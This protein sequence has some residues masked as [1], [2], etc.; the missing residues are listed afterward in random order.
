MIL[1]IRIYLTRP[2]ILLT[3]LYELVNLKGVIDLEG[4][5]GICQVNLFFSY[6][7]FSWKRSETASFLSQYANNV[8]H[9][10]FVYFRFLYFSLLN[11]SLTTKRNSTNLPR[12]KPYLL[13]NFG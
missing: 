10:G 4:L 9:Q 6:S 2:A 12:V 1:N 13:F 11:F 3:H 5:V 7:I 8:L